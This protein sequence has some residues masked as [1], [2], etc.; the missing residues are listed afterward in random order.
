MMQIAIDESGRHGPNLLA[1]GHFVV[2]ST[3]LTDAEAE[4]LLDHTLGPPPSNAGEWKWQYLA[5]QPDRAYRFLDA[6]DS[7]KVVAVVTHHRFFGWCK[8]IDTLL[9]EFDI[10]LNEEAGD[11]ML[12]A[13]LA[14][15]SWEEVRLVVDDVLGVFVAACRDLLVEKNFYWFSRRSREITSACN[16]KWTRAKILDPIALR[17][18]RLRRLLLDHITHGI[19]GLREKRALAGIMWIHTCPLSGLLLEGGK[20]EVCAAGSPPFTTKYA[21]TMLS[22][23]G[24]Q[25]SLV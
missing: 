23:A 16:D 1:G 14:Q 2:G 4:T 24:R 18:P 8:L 3:S 5:K 7:R 22:T 19:G 25:R 9:Y 13:L 21:Q 15:R 10:Y 11:Q 6:L 20:V 17:A 12:M